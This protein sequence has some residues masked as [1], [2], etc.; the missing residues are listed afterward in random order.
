MILEEVTAMTTRHWQVFADLAAH[1]HAA[2]ARVLEAVPG[3]ALMQFADGS[4]EASM[5][6]DAATEHEAT[7]FV[8]L[9]LLELGMEAT[10]L[11][12][13]QAQPDDE[14]PLSPLV[15]DDPAM[16]RAEEWARSLAHPLPE[17]A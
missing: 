6:I 5:V 4:G 3:S 8:R 7:L 17:M 14:V 2:H 9:A 12:V 16:A 1:D 10:A 15:F 11:S 13:E